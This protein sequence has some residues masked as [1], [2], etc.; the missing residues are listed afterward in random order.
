MSRKN[1]EMLLVWQNRPVMGI[2]YNISK[3]IKII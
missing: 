1:S 2:G 3:D